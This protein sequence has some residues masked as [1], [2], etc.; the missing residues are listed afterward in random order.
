MFVSI[1]AE[2]FLPN[3][4]ISRFGSRQANE[5]GCIQLL[6]TALWFPPQL[7]GKMCGT[8]AHK[9]IAKGNA[10]RTR[11][12]FLCGK[13]ENVLPICIIYVALVEI[14]AL[15]GGKTSEI[16]RTLLCFFPHRL[17]NLNAHAMT[18]LSHIVAND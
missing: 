16:M 5:I 8:R 18:V 4:W 12:I 10:I 17:R 1:F 9:L 15:T 11:Y 7:D 2:V 3:A 13:E 14:S 6:A